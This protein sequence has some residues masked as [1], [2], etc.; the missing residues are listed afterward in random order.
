[1]TGTCRQ[2]NVT[3]TIAAKNPCCLEQ[4]ETKQ[5]PCGVFWCKTQVGSLADSVSPQQSRLPAFATRNH[6]VRMRQYC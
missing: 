2:S 6:V 1:M 5:V 3:V 4:A